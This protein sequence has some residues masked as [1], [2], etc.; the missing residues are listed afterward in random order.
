MDKQRSAEQAAE[1]LT[2]SLDRLKEKSKEVKAK[3]EQEKRRQNLPLDSNLGNPEWE[4]NAADGHL[5]V[6]EQD[7][8]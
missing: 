8:D 2:K 7:D 6:H 1:D 4:E 5:D 3:I